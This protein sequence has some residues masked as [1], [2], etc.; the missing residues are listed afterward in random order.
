[1]TDRISE[2]DW[3]QWVSN[4]ITKLFKNYLTDVQNDAIEQL[5]NADPASFESVEKYALRCATLRSF[6]D[7]MAQS[8]DFDSIS[9]IL[10]ET[11][12]E[13]QLPNGY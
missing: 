13:E 3:D 8:T 9:D 7:G 5:L 4:P 11:T 12:E 10:V 1:M 2:D 6:V